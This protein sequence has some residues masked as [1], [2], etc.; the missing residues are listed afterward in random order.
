MADECKPNMVDLEQILSERCTIGN[1]LKVIIGLPEL[2]EKLGDYTIN[3]AYKR[4]DG[5]EWSKQCFSGRWHYRL[6]EEHGFEDCMADCVK[7]ARNLFLD[8]VDNV[9]SLYKDSTDPA[10]ILMLSALKQEREVVISSFSGF[11][12]S[13]EL[14]KEQAQK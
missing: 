5:K 10:D 2:P 6:S 12:T 14:V 13:S 4:L 11:A 8:M 3:V 7:Y 1:T 9:E